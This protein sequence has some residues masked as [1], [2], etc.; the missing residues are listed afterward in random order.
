MF[1]TIWRPHFIQLSF[2]LFFFCF[3]GVRQGDIREYFFLYSPP[4]AVPPPFTRD[5][6]HGVIHLFGKTCSLRGLVCN[7]SALAP[8]GWGRTF[9]WV[10]SFATLIS[11]SSFLLFFSIFLPKLFFFYTTTLLDTLY[12]IPIKHFFFTL[13]SIL[14]IFDDVRS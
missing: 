6:R 12:C 13:P 2:C 11:S 7:H 14:S 9:R 4:P 10:P 8:H 3:S 1:L 5:L